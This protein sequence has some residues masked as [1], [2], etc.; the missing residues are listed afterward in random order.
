MNLGLRFEP[1]STWYQLDGYFDGGT[2]PWMEASRSSDNSVI[3]SGAAEAA[4][5][6]TFSSEMKDMYIAGCSLGCKKFQNLDDAKVACV[7]EGTCGGVT[8]TGSPAAYEL[9]S[10]F[11]A[12]TSPFGESSWLI[13]NAGSPSCHAPKPVV[14]DP[15]WIKRGAAAYAGLNRTDP[16]AIWSFQGWAIVGWNSEKQASQVKGFIDATPKDKFVV[17]DM[18][19]NGAGEWKQWHSAAFWGAKFIWTTLHDFGGTD[20]MKGNLAQINEIPFAAMEG[21]HET[22]VWGTGF[23]PEGIDQNPVYYEFIIAA[24]W[25][26]ARVTN[27]TEHVILRSHHR[28]GLP[29]FNRDISQAWALLVDSTYAQDLSVQDSTGLP[30]LPGHASQ[31]EA[32]R[33]TPTPR[34]CKTFLAWQ[35]MIS[36]ATDPSSGLDPQL[37]TFRYDLINL[38]REMLAQLATPSSMNFSDA[39]EAKT[40]NSATIQSTGGSYIELL[41]DIVSQCAIRHPEIRPWRICLINHFAE[42]GRVQGWESIC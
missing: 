27:I 3:V 28:Y 42:G 39:I 38:G 5:N 6:C 40:L 36:A 26:S 14:S 19:V 15:M 10:A 11:S 8:R 24:N 33:F 35:K 7:A 12:T 29:K 30:H 25:R 34:L 31:F 1:S 32:D 37:V 20:G 21:E 18:S 23:T 22:S 17:I 9:R 13:T 4:E 16:D 41:K 2:A